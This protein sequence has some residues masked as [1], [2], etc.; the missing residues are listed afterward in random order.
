MQL[1]HGCRRSAGTPGIADHRQ[2][3]GAGGVSVLALRSGRRVDWSVSGQS[4]GEPEDRKG[5]VAALA[6]N[7]MRAPHGSARRRLVPQD[8]RHVGGLRHGFRG[9]HDDR[10]TAGL[11]GDDGVVQPL[12]GRLRV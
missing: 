7:L 1:G 4:D 2:S 9:Y 6:V 3:S 11:G 5:A 10:T 8:R 12:V